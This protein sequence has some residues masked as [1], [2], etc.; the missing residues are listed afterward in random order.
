[1]S[2][3]AG[4]VV[5]GV[6]TVLVRMLGGGRATTGTRRAW[7]PQSL[8]SP[9]TRDSSPGP[10]FEPAFEPFQAGEMATRTRRSVL[11]SQREMLFYR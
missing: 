11:S 10:G 6:V 8:S 1:M 7:V 2:A 3:G 5:G 4:G 9:T